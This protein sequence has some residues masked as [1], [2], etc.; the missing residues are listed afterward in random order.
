MMAKEI[1]AYVTKDGKIFKDSKEAELHEKEI[2]KK[3]TLESFASKFFFNGMVESDLVD[4][5]EEFLEQFN[6]EI[7]EKK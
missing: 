5:L 1:K 2:I 3:Q 6:L 7:Q 4:V